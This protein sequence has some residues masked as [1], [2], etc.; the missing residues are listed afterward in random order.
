MAAVD[1]ECTMIGIF[2]DNLLSCADEAGEAQL[3][4]DQ[5]FIG[6]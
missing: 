5:E 2:P 3:L 4:S 1:G 6:E